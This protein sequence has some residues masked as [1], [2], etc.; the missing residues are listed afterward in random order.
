MRW[1]APDQEVHQKGHGE[2][3]QKDCQAR[4]LNREDAMDH[5]RW[6]KLIKPCL[7]YNLTGIWFYCVSKQ[8]GASTFYHTIFCNNN[9]GVFTAKNY[10]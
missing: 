9:N 1:R 7:R 5:G 6:N 3:V 4:N 2:V 8:H 10:D